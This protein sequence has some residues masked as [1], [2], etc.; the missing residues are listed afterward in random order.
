MT[1]ETFTMSCREVVS[2]VSDDL[3]VTFV[4]NFVKTNSLNILILKLFPQRFQNILFMAVL[5]EEETKELGYLI[6]TKYIC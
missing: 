3:T 4:G 2:H 5:N 6:F 1:E